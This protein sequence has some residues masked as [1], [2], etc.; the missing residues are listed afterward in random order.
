MTEPLP[1]AGFTVAVTAAR[2]ADEL[3]TLLTRRGAAVVR[4]PAIR[5]VPLPDDAD[6][7]AATATVLDA[8]PDVVVATTGIGFRGWVEAAEGWGLGDKLL[9]VLAG[10]RLLARGPK[11]RGAI[12][13]AGLADAWMA[14][15]TE[16]C[17]EVLGYLLGRGV[18]GLR[19]AVQLHGEP[20]PDFVAALRGAGAAV[21]EVPVYRWAPPVDPIAL[22]RMLDGVLAGTVDAVTFTSALAVT[23]VLE[24]AAA[25]GLDGALVTA[26]RFGVLA[27]CVGPVTAGRLE[28]RGVVTVQPQRARLGS[29]VRRLAAELPARSPRLEV[30]GVRL[31][32]RGQ[33]VLVDGR[34]RPVAPA[35]MALLRALARV[36]GAVLARADLLRA[37]PGG[38]ADEH[39]VEA[40]VARLRSALG[41]PGLLETVVKRGY[42]LA[43]P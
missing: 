2:R 41:V 18:D 20:Q 33:A 31:E 36:Q 29:M 28:A 7:L 43:P 12:R 4:A 21:I 9:D 15:S 16:S 23:S 11:A 17:E 38:G 39:A 6:L 1:L 5:I 24:R 34:L 26:L 22:D 10:A 14:E 40:A 25:R 27:C 37:L 35:G 19:V 3:T 8:R 42:R 13:A 32:L 30:A